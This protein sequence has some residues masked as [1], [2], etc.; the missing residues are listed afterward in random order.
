MATTKKPHTSN[1]VKN[2]YTRRHYDR[3]TLLLP[4]GYRERLKAVA[5]HKGVS[6]NGMF[7]QVAR[8]LV[9]VEQED[10][11]PLYIPD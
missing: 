7:N 8:E 5:E 6:V 2:K 11:K 1:A 4:K 3:M 9:G 10:W